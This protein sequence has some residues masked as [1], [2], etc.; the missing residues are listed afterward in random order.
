M[1]PSI[2]E[3]TS[4]KSSSSSSSPSSSSL[5]LVTDINEPTPLLG[6]MC[7]WRRV[8]SFSNAC[9]FNNEKIDFIS[10]NVYCI[11]FLYMME[12]VEPLLIYNNLL[13]WAG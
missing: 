1:S 8:Y 6:A 5:V 7:S 13:N 10:S 4:L 9:D 2:S 12:R 11:P 3:I